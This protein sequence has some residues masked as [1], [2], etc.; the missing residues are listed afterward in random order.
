[1]RSRDGR[2]YCVPDEMAAGF[3]IP[4]PLLAETFRR[5]GMAWPV[6]GMTPDPFL[7]E[8]YHWGHW[9]AASALAGVLAQFPAWGAVPEA[10]AYVYAASPAPVA[11]TEG[12]IFAACHRGD[13]ATVAAILDANPSLL[14]ARTLDKRQPLHLAAS[15]GSA[16]LVEFLIARGAPVDARDM[17][18]LTPLHVA[19][20]KG[21]AEAAEALLRH[22]APVNVRHNYGKTPLGAALSLDSR[23]LVTL[24]AQYGGIE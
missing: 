21:Q 16:A 24:L 23:P 14:H 1:M 7:V 8:A 15:S 9:V 6:A 18:G 2:L 22:G 10:L 13:I 5:A 19:A 3:Y 4:P 11:P 20:T 17:F 12:D